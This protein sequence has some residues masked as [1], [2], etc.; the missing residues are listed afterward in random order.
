MPLPI[1]K[2]HADWLS[3]IEISGPFISIPVLT[4]AFPQG[5]EDVPAELARSLQAD[6][7]FWQENPS[8]PAVHSAWVRLVL[9]SLLG[10]GKEVL[11]SGQ[12]IPAGLKAEFP[13]HEET[14]RPDFILA[15]PSEEGKER[16]PRLLIQVFPPTQSLDNA[17]HG[18]R[19]VASVG[20]RMMELLHATEIRLGLVTNGEQWMLVDAPRGVT[21]GFTTWYASLWFDE[22]ATLNAFQ[23]LLGARRFF[24]VAEDETLENLLAR[25]ADHQWE[26]T[27]QLGLQVRHA[28]EILIQSLDRADQNRGRK[29]LGADVSPDLLYEAALTMMMRLVFML[30]AEERKLLPIDDDQYSNYYA[31]STLREQ[32]Q[33]Q[34]SQN[35]EEVLERRFDAWSRLLAVFRAVYGGI[36][37]QDL[38][39]PAYGGSL[40]DPDKY[41][42]LE[43]RP[44]GTNWQET[45]ANPLPVDN[46]TVLHLLDALQTLRADG[47]MRRL[48]FRALDVEQIG[49]VY[50]GLLDHHAVRTTKTVLGLTGTKKLEPEIALSKLEQTRA[51][52]EE[53]L[54]NLL[55]DETQKSMLALRNALTNNIQ[56]DALRIGKLRSA[57]G[58]DDALLARVLPFAGLIRMDDF[59]NPEV[60]LPGSV[61]VTAGTTRRATGTHYTPRSLTEPIV[62]H[63]LEPLVYEG[64]AEGWPREKWRLRSPAELL[65]LKICDMAMGSAGFLVQVVRYLAERLI[66][67]LTLDYEKSATDDDLLSVFKELSSD[68]DR[69]NYARRLVAEHCIYG[70]DKNPLAVEIAK[71]SLWLVTLAKEKPFTFLNHALKCGDSLVGTGSDDFLRWANRKKTP[72]MSLDQEVLR[73]ELEKARGLRKQLESFVA[74]DVRDAERKQALLLEADAAMGHVKRGADLLAGV[75]LL[76]L[77]P[78][79]AEDLQLRM[80]DPYIA[81][82]LDGS[83]DLAKYPD[84]ANALEAAKKEHAFHW[85]YE[86]PEVFDTAAGG[87]SA[88]VGNPPFIGGK[89]IVIMTN[90][91]YILYLKGNYPSA[92]NTTDI[93]AYFFLRAYEK[94][95]PKGAFGLIAT[96]TIAQGDTRE[97]GLD[98]LINHGANIYFAFSSTPWPGVASVYVSIVHLIK[99]SYLGEIRLDNKV[100]SA[101]SSLL[102][103][104]I[105]LAKP[106]ILLNNSGKSYVGVFVRGIGFV[107]ESDEAI[108]LISRDPRNADVIHPYISG[109]DLASRYDQSPSRYII[110]FSN[111][112]LERAEEYPD[113]L[114]IL[115]DRVYPERQLVNQKDHREKWWQ[116]ANLRPGLYASIG[117]YQRVLLMPRVSKYLIAS[118][119]DVNQVFSEQT[120]LVSSDKGS[121]FALIQSNFHEPWTRKFASTLETR[122]RYTPV[123]V[124]ETFPF[125]ENLVGLEQIGETYHEYRRQIMLARQEGLTSTYNRFHM[126]EEGAE[127]IVR[128][129]ELHVEMDCAVAAA[130]RWNDLELG[131]NFHETAQGIRFTIS[132]SA[133]R[134]ILSRLLKL[135]HER[136]EEEQV[137]EGE[138]QKS[139]SGAKGRKGKKKTK[140]TGDGQMEFF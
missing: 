23:S 7:E 127:D 58:N 81:G 131:H 129:R 34:A 82:L 116:F 14:L 122:L 6:F 140:N 49:H 72:E 93:A 39:L 135:N 31:V 88:F 90:N 1:A 60:I 76:G 67:S 63:T 18:S 126:P 123:D 133:R 80:V 9:E 91:N 113:C 15:G 28:V 87:F 26:I 120:V 111:W 64:V 117:T 53:A 108:D 17:V 89:R 20:T 57:C 32:L 100:V 78:Q 19:W 54:L 61:Y 125:P 46:R 48:S 45:P 44:A 8:D 139:P 38:H 96:N 121:V 11:I 124:F 4:D 35:G 130:Y 95:K 37:H 41:P 47:E 71:L 69:L 27:D 138:V 3:L 112:S 134:E 29:L 24:G 66:E 21:T 85:E 70:V 62:Q 102:D 79:E 92:K 97:A 84:F 109:D 51:Q 22:R 106:K 94:L 36:H 119:A 74:L 128:L 43:G 77:T 83:I 13:E 52:S 101:I 137:A 104:G 40:F 103:E 5:L 110:D 65:D 16:K 42:F 136:W 73:E 68:E 98:Y 55:K 30:S 118:F 86:Y 12:A 10:Y 105:N 2:Y 75:K 25:S 99:G 33:T 115:K 132:E 50:E 59:E 107:L 56:E 114:S